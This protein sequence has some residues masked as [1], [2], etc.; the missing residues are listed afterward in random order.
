MILYR[1]IPVSE[2]RTEL[3][4]EVLYKWLR[5]EFYEPGE[6]VLFEGDIPRAE[7]GHF[8]VFK[9]ECEVLQFPDESVP[10]MKLLYLAKKK[11]WEEAKLLLTTAPIVAKIPKL[12]GF[13]ELST[14]T[15]VK[16][17]AS[18]RISPKM[19]EPA[20]VL[21]LPK[22]A[23]LDCLKSRTSEDV[24]GASTSEAI[25]FLRQSGL[26]NR[27]SPKDLVSAAS[28]MIRRT[29]VQGEILYYKGE[30]AK[31]IFL[32]VSGEFLLDTGDFMVNGQPAPFVRAT[33]DRCYHLTSGSILGEE[34]VVGD[35][36][37]YIST[38]AVVSSAA[39]VFEAVSF[40]MNFLAEKVGGLRYSALYYRDKLC[41][42]FAQPIAEQ[43]NPYTFFNSLRKSISHIKPYRGL[44]SLAAAAC[45]EHRI[46]EQAQKLHNAKQAELRKQKMKNMRGGLF[47]AAT[48][49][50]MQNAEKEKKPEDDNPFLS[51]PRTLTGVGLHRAVDINKHAKKLLQTISRSHAKET[52]LFEQLNRIPEEE[53]YDEEMVHAEQLFEQSLK[54]YY[55]RCAAQARKMKEEE[56]NRRRNAVTRASSAIKF[57]SAS[58]TGGLGDDD[59]DHKDTA[60]HDGSSEGQPD[61][62]LEAAREEAV[63]IADQ[64]PFSANLR[65]HRDSVIHDMNMAKLYSMDIAM[66]PA[67]L[68]ANKLEMYFQWVDSLTLM[69]HKNLLQQAE[70]TAEEL[71]DLLYHDHTTHYLLGKNLDQAMNANSVSEEERW[72]ELGK[73]FQQYGL[74]PMDITLQ[75]MGSTNENE[76]VPSAKLHPPAAKKGGDA[77]ATTGATG[78]DDSLPPVNE[79]SHDGNALKKT[80]DETKKSFKSQRSN[81]AKSF[82]S[83]KSETSKARST[84]SKVSNNTTST[85]NAAGGGGTS[86]SPMKKV[87]SYAAKEHEEKLIKAHLDSKYK[88][89]TPSSWRDDMIQKKSQETTVAHVFHFLRAST[90]DNRRTVFLYVVPPSRDPNA[91]NQTHHPHHPA[92]LPSAAT[93]QPTHPGAKLTIVTGASPR[94]G[95][96]EGG[97]ETQLHRGDAPSLVD[98]SQF[99]AEPDYFMT[100]LRENPLSHI[101]RTKRDLDAW[102]TRFLNVRNTKRNSSGAELNKADEEAAALKIVEKV[103]LPQ[104]VRTHLKEDLQHYSRNAVLAAAHEQLQNSE[105]HFMRIIFGKEL[106]S[107]QPPKSLRNS[108]NASRNTSF[109]DDDGPDGGRRRRRR[110]NPIRAAMDAAVEAVGGEQE[111]SSTLLSSSTPTL[112][113]LLTPPPT[114]H[115][116]P[117]IPTMPH[118]P[119][120]PAHTHDGKHSPS[121]V[122]VATSEKEY[123]ADILRSLPTLGDA[124]FS[125][126]L[127]APSADPHHLMNEPSIMTMP[128]VA[129]GDAESAVSQREYAP[130][131]IGQTKTE[132]SFD[133]G[134]TAGSS[135]AEDSD[136]DDASSIAGDDA[137]A[138]SRR[139]SQVSQQANADGAATSTTAAAIG[140]VIGAEGHADGFGLAHGHSDHHAPM[141]GLPPLQAPSTDSTVIHGGAVEPSAHHH[142]PG[143]SA[144]IGILPTVSQ[145]AGNASPISVGR[146]GRNKAAAQKVYIRY[147]DTKPASSALQ[148]FE[149]FMKSQDPQFTKAKAEGRK[150]ANQKCKYRLAPSLRGDPEL[151]AAVIAQQ[152][153]AART[154]A[155]LGTEVASLTSNSQAS[156]TD[157]LQNTTLGTDIHLRP[158]VSLK[159]IIMERL[160][161][162]IAVFQAM[163]PKATMIDHDNAHIE[164]WQRYTIQCIVK[165]KSGERKILPSIATKKTMESLALSGKRYR[166]ESGGGYSLITLASKQSEEPI[167]GP[168]SYLELYKN[169]F[170]I[171]T[172]RRMKEKIQKELKEAAKSMHA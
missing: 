61:N 139:P 23:L 127:R 68:H 138:M 9:G 28:S 66:D 166:G 75:W 40:G 141:M 86:S 133:V 85:N 96:A 172:S 149:S 144:G 109:L 95:A 46:Q 117:P 122:S 157:V 53:K 170:H 51:Y 136:R 2:L 84:T 110:K 87:T 29:L 50:T 155:I 152:Q 126:T 8:T 15:G 161:A 81:T 108:W 132:D 150:R 91:P 137:N 76:V 69:A 98:Y 52:I 21:I 44:E 60:T 125:S 14:L 143:E 169:S 57:F 22:E 45:A 38:A 7:D 13:G 72:A 49:M 128:S 16:R 33:D 64:R 106:D 35:G 153:K 94:D 62:P 124:H 102:D 63:R 118:T 113:T 154:A 159:R 130:P 121:A 115:G 120:S 80:V 147:T 25:D 129:E 82:K 146:R 70:Q 18:I 156:P 71:H 89:Y 112:R 4:I 1:H 79:S 27:I 65:R 131:A 31:S 20:E 142:H 167:A 5:L 107:Y 41:W 11:R 47:P 26:A 12:S 54:E 148:E 164:D 151:L 78:K 105:T 77:H 97:K 93:S 32:V 10:L 171:P 24:E 48:L 123:E 67:L 134:S 165:E 104:I 163:Y 160:K 58:S 56:E 55:E 119:G 3:E 17:A 92:A 145:D 114:Y 101:Q 74:T 83:V 73:I 116:V 59:D 30:T 158:K 103:T 90:P 111:S 168:T 162:E 140:A 34:G 36:N 19:T 99:I 135:I 100:A 42:D 88:S 37:V 39:V 6:T 43:N